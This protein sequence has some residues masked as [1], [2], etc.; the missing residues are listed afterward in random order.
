MAELPR[1]NTP[2]MIKKRK[3]FSD[4]IADCSLV[5]EIM[6]NAK[7]DYYVNGTIPDIK[8][9]TGIKPE[10]D[11]PIELPD[12]IEQ[13]K[14]LRRR[15]QNSNSKDQFY[16]NYQQDTK[17]TNPNPMPKGPKRTKIELRMK[18]RTEALEQIEIKL[19]ELT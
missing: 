5:I 18:S 4:Q 7:D 2:E 10:A 6:H 14:D 16:L 9:L 19:N 17:G 8:A 11:K 3:V 12:S 13:L 15:M 1:E